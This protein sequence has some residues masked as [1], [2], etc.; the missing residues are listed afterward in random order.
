MDS[1]DHLV[2]GFGIAIGLWVVYHLFNGSF[3]MSQSIATGIFL[4]GFMVV[5]IFKIKDTQNTKD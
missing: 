2:W 5:I 4:I 1:L 3:G